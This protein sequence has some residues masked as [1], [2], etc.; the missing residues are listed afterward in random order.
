MA[1]QQIVAAATQSKF[2]ATANYEERMHF[3]RLNVPTPSG[4]D[5]VRDR[6]LSNYTSVPYI[7][8]NNKENVSNKA[9]RFGK[10]VV[11]AGL[12]LSEQPFSRPVMKL[13]TGSFDDIISACARSRNIMFVERLMVEVQTFYL[14]RN[15]ELMC[16]LLFR[17]VVLMKTKTEWQKQFYAFSSCL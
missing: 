6:C 14:I 3:S 7:P 1:L 8:V 15:S 17:K 12:R 4:A 5:L 9:V 10:E 13:L 2:C 16:N 11:D